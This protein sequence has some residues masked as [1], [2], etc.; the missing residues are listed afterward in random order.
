L[1]VENE[2]NLFDGKLKIEN[3][4]RSVVTLYLLS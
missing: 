4:L 1:K 3:W 2:K